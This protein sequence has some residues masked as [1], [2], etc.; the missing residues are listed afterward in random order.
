MF[1]DAA[2]VLARRYVIRDQLPTLVCAVPL[3]PRAARTQPIDQRLRL[4]DTFALAAGLHRGPRFTV[5]RRARAN[6]AL[7]TVLSDTAVVLV[8]DVIGDD[9]MAMRA[10]DRLERAGVFLVDV[11]ALTRIGDGVARAVSGRRTGSARTV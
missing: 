3:S 6:R 4:A 7:P 10:V 11:A 9:A 1:N 8:T 2:Q 5:H